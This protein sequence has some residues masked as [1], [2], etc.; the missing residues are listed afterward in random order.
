MKKSGLSFRN[1]TL[2]TGVLFHDF[3]LCCMALIPVGIVGIILMIALFP[4]SVTAVSDISVFNINYTHDQLKFR[5]FAES[6]EPLITATAVLLGASASV[7]LFSFMHDKSRSSFYFSLGLTRTSMY[8][9]R[10]GA[11]LVVCGAALFLPLLCSLF[12]NLKALGAYDGIYS[13]A[14]ATAVILFLQAAAGVLIGQA[15]CFLAGSS[16]E[17]LLTAVTVAMIPFI[18]FSFLNELMKTFLWGNVY[19]VSAYSGSVIR[20]GLPSGLA[21]WNP[22]CFSWKLIRKYGSFSR[23]MENSMPD[24]V[25]YGVI[26]VWLFL[27]ILFSAVLYYLFQRYTAERSGISGLFF[28]ARAVVS[29]IWPMAAFA[30]VLR[31]LQSVEPVV[32]FMASAVCACL[33]YAVIAGSYSM[34]YEKRNVKILGASGLIV[35]FA[36]SAMITRAGFF[37]LY[38]QIPGEG[39]TEKVEI[40]YVGDPSLIPDHCSITQNGQGIYSSGTVVFR[41]DEAV[42]ESVRLEKEMIRQGR[43]SLSPE[44]NTSETVYPYDISMKWTDRKGREYQRY[45]DRIRAST[46]AEFLKLEDTVEL[47]EMI[48]ETV[49]GQMSDRLWNSEA[50]LNGE[51]YVSDSWMRQIRH[52]TLSDDMRS[53]LLRAVSEDLSVRKSG[54][55]Y[56]PEEDQTGFLYFTLNGGNDLEQLKAG[57]AVTKVYFNSSSEQTVSVLT[58]WG[59]LPDVTGLPGAEEI[60]SVQIQKF[61]PYSGMNR[62][63]EPVSFFFSEYRTSSDDDFVLGQDFGTRPLFTEEKQIQELAAASVSSAFMEDM[64]C[65]AVFEMSSGHFVYR[66][67]PF[68]REPELIKGKIN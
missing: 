8:L 33:L 16:G 61:D 49:M 48:R 58:G 5:F 39:M 15:G 37:G 30:A 21:V 32:A 3:R 14:A 60:R 51:I 45:Y 53:L 23:S 9:V 35:F 31:A 18:V 68:D 47:K 4:V 63:K 57:T 59:A 24:P 65:L 28:S 41:S 12:L 44:K 26:L 67:I 55:R 36:V 50:F 43:L 40:S 11:C 66:Y 46:L 1:N 29:I 6:L 56:H 64:G 7:R 42:S 27:C 13:Y 25:E 54:S 62:L 2:P 10:T 38:Y 19:G 20:E 22:V 17:A 52:L 34:K